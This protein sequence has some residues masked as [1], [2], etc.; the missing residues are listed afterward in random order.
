[1]M[2]DLIGMEQLNKSK[3]Y[4]TPII[5]IINIE[6]ESILE[7]SNLGVG[8]DTEDWDGPIIWG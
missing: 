1:M 8:E 7:S 4:N 5:E 2:M 6:V 3:K